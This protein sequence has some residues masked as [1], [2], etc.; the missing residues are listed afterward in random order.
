MF[1]EAGNLKGLVIVYDVSNL[2]LLRAAGSR[3]H[4]CSRGHD[5]LFNT[6]L[7]MQ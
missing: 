6:G 5:F 3:I 4:Y 2:V 1:A 7:I